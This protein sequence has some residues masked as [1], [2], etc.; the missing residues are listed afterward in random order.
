MNKNILMAG[1]A[2]ALLL[3][4]IALAQTSGNAGA[5]APANGSSAGATDSSPSS[6]NGAASTPSGSSSATGAG[7][8]TSST[9][10]R[11]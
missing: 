3:G 4:S 11:G 8:S 10:E 6:A 2:S 7:A 1:A 5:P 9:G